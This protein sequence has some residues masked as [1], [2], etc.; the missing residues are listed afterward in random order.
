M[1]FTVPIL[2]KMLE[3]VL[4]IISLNIVKSLILRFLNSGY[5]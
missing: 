3:G 2:K 1:I 4:E 5:N